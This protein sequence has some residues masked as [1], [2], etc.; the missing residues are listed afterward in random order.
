MIA[1]APRTFTRTALLA[2]TC[3][4]LAGCDP[5]FDIGGAYFPAWILCL[6]AALLG[7]MAIRELLLRTGI[8]RHIFWRPAAYTGCFLAIACWVWLFFFSN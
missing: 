3:L 5:I 4:P 2:L 1:S 8:D 7:T 6:I